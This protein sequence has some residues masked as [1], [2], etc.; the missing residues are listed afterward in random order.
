VTSP[1]ASLANR[2]DQAVESRP[3]AGAVLGERDM[4]AFVLFECLI[5]ASY[6][7]IYM[8]YRM[9]DPELFL[10]SQQHLNQDLGVVNTLILLTSSWWMARGVQSAREKKFELASRQVVLTFLCGLAFVGSKLTEWS[11]KLRERLEFSTNQ[12]FWFYYFLTGIH[13]LHVMIGLIFLGVVVYQLRSPERRSL[14][15]VET[16]ATYW[17]MVDFLWVLIFALVYVMR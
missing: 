14:L 4:W 6:F 7:V 5:F 3:G 1:A 2:L 15:V 13:V 8:L 11:L 16:G 10:R 9:A 17:H 12:F